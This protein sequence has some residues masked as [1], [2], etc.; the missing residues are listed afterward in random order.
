[1]KKTIYCIALP[2]LF[3]ITQSAYCVISTQLDN[4]GFSI[5]TPAD[6]TDKVGSMNFGATDF[7]FNP[8]ITG[9]YS[10]HRFKLTNGAVWIK[11]GMTIGSS[12]N[13]ISDVGDGSASIEIRST[14][15]G[16]LPSR[17]TATQA[18]AISTPSEALFLYATD[19]SGGTIT[20]KGWWGYDGAVW[21]KINSGAGSFQAG[22]Q[23]QDEG[24][25]LGTSGTVNNINFIGNDIKVTRTSNSLSVNTTAV[26]QTLTD[27]ATVTF[28]AAS[29]TL[30]QITLVGNRTLAFSNFN[31]GDYLT[32]I[33]IQ[34]GT[35]GRT[36][37][38]PAGVK[39]IGGGGG[40]VI[41]STAAASQDIITFF[42]I[43]TTIYCNYATNYN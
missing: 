41:L 7:S 2:L 4:F 35:G 12:I 26:T 38:L 28:D 36:L 42:K 3:F 17:M 20:S 5:G 13:P 34:D 32:L 37:T 24:T 10:A 9:A 27:G 30:A 22:V 19:G 15:Q 1:M 16:F 40:A 29:G 11:G 23:F 6:P 18:E 21:T 31:A 8:P 43:G 39:V 14:T 25:N 33:V